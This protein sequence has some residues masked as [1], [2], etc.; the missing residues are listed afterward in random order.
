[1]AEVLTIIIYCLL[2]VL[3]SVAIICGIKLIF[4]LDK[5]DALVDDVT[6]KVKSLDRIFELID[7]ATNKMSMISEV[8]I[9]FIN[10][11]LKK[12]FAKPK[13]SKKSKEEDEID[14]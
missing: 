7:F 5:V 13:K 2:I 14:E 8:I 1:M 3:I 11:G 4:T 12:I 9:S 6:I 10:G